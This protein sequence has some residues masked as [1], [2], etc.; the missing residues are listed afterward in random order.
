RVVTETSLGSSDQGVSGA[1]IKLFR[2]DGE[3]STPVG[4]LVNT[5]VDGT[6]AFIVQNGEYYVQV[7]KEGYRS[8]VTSPVRVKQNVFRERVSLIEIP[9]VKPLVANAPFIENAAV[10]A[11]N[12]VNQADYAS[13][14]VRAVVES[15]TVQTANIVAAPVILTVTVASAANAIN[16]F[17]ILAYFQYLLTQPLLLFT[18]KKRKK[19][20]IVYNALT[21]QPIDLAIV[22]LLEPQTKLVLQTKV[23][24][25]FGRFFFLVKSGTYVIDVVKPNYVFPTQA[26]AH[27]KEDVDL[28]DLYHGEVITGTEEAVLAMNIPADPIVA[29][30]IPSRIIWKKRLRLLQQVISFSS[31]PL[32]MIVLFITPSI[33][34]VGMLAFQ[35]VTY[36]IFRR[37][38]VPAKPKNWGIAY[39]TKTRKGLQNVIVRIFDKKFN[40]LL[41]TQV[42]DRKGKYG[43]LVKRNIYYVTA[44]ASKYKKNVSSDID[45]SKREDALI[46]LNMPMEPIL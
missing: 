7:E 14:V 24:D 12:I 13:K 38:A 25:K 11:S 46:D 3:T 22:R 15:P 41:E 6:Y 20:G 19:W 18:R 35:F 39:D 17:N 30:E 27:Q 2:R 42:T 33:W 34:T 8:T 21:K 16:T 36:A 31:I 29:E 1:R 10:L 28:V 45:L 26:L 43:F 44:E 4:A 5:N 32:S 37:T 9:V 23:T 40:K